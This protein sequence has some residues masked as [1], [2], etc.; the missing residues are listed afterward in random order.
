MYKYLE[1]FK[2][3]MIKA[4]FNPP[5]NIIANG[6]F[7]RFSTNGKPTDRAGWYVI[8]LDNI[9]GGSFGDWR[10]GFSQDWRAD[11]G[12]E[13]S[14]EENDLVKNRMNEIQLARK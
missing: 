7:Q 1:Q 8:Y 14:R 9:P 2:S 11:I 5:D 3:E 13:L 12:R 10:T 4:G 6:Y